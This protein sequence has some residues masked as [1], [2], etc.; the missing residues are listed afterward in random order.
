MRDRVEEN[1]GEF[2]QARFSLRGAEFADRRPAERQALFPHLLAPAE[3]DGVAGWPRR[4]VA[5]PDRPAEAHEE[6]IAGLEA[7]GF[8]VQREFDYAVDEPNM[9]I[10]AGDA[11]I[12]EGDARAGRELDLDNVDG[13]AA[14]RRRDVAP[15]I[16]AFRIAPGRLIG[17]PGEGP[18]RALRLREQFGERHAQPAADLVEELRG[19]ARFAALD[20]RQHGPANV[21]KPG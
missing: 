12:V 11:V 15:Q 3:N 13:R 21:G 6:A 16:M 2:G 1:V 8:I 19:R 10:L 5:K 18:R 17:A 14:P 20:P 7:D 9:L 4:R